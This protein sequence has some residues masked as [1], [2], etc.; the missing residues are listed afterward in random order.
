MIMLIL[1]LI[2]LDSITGKNEGTYTKG[3]FINNKENDQHRK[4][5]TGVETLT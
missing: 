5:D 1:F 3:H 4:L 2:I